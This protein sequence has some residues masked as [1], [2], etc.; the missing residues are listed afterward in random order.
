MYAAC[1][2]MFFAWVFAVEWLSFPRR[3]AVLPSLLFG[4]AILY[5]YVGARP[6]LGKP[7]SLRLKLLLG[8]PILFAFHFLL[9]AIVPLVLIIYML[10]RVATNVFHLDRIPAKWWGVKPQIAIALLLFLGVFP[11]SNQLYALR[12]LFLYLGA[13]EPPMLM[14]NRFYNVNAGGYRGPLVEIRRDRRRLLFP[15]DSV[16]FG[17]SH[18]WDDAYPEQ[19]KKAL[20]KRG[21]EDVDVLNLG[22]PSQSLVQMEAKFDD[23][24]AYEPDAILLTS[25]KHY[26]K[27]VHHA[28]EIREFDGPILDIQ[29]EWAPTPP[30]L[31]PILA[32][33]PFRSAYLGERD[34]SHEPN[35]AL[36]EET[37][38]RFAERARDAGVRLVLLEYPGITNEPE[39][40]D[41]Q[42]AVAE[43]FGLEWVPLRHHFS[44][45][46]DYQF[47]DGIHPH[48][49]GHRRIAES[50]AEHLTR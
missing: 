6:W 18:P 8:I 43:K 15:A 44:E 14:E 35:L 25:G 11:F 5:Y 23:Y 36:Y 47:S 21:V 45:K 37:L 19:T 30:L 7:K 17:F 22:I 29:R 27:S 26:Q 12:G 34:E 13:V 33:G 16:T 1:G 41:V 31:G 2:G 28:K 48:E 9:L 49:W 24:L 39:I 42:H 38:T 20:A 4:A 40:D 10:C 46:S 32:M 3:Y 50:I